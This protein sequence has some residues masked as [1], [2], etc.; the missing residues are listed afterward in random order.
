MECH[1]RY[2]IA[3]HLG[4][5]SISVDILT[6]LG[7]FVAYGI[8]LLAVYPGFFVY[9]AVDE[10]IQVETGNFTTHHPLPHVLILGGVIKLVYKLTGSYNAGIA[11]YTFFQVFFFSLLFTYILAGLRK[12]S[13]N[14]K[15]HLFFSLYYIL[16][17][18]VSMYVLCST[19]DSLFSAFLVLLFF[20]LR[21]SFL[22]SVN[23]REFFLI[24]CLDSCG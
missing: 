23:K 18:V 4:K 9:D 16:F 2:F 24:R 22:I 15:S 1:Y 21:D 8:V 20:L 13:M 12:E 6:F 7:L 17:P 10:W 19:K 14:L 11:L 3:L 5:K